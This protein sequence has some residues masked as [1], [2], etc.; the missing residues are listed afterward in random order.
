[1]RKT[2]SNFIVSFDYFDNISIPSFTTV[3]GALIGK[4]NASFSLVFSIFT[5]IVKKLL[6]TTRNKQKKY[7][8][9]F[10]LARTKL[11]SIESKIPQALIKNQ[12]SRFYNNY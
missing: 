1:M 3:V 5:G 12:S 2:L 10:M 4:G 6:K 8:K 7:N 11:N 9:N